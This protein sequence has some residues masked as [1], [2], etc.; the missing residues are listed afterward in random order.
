[1]VGNYLLCQQLLEITQQ[2]F[3]IQ[4]AIQLFMSYRYLQ[5][6]IRNLAVRIYDN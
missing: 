3:Q 2:Q 1:M 4:V 5:F 6:N